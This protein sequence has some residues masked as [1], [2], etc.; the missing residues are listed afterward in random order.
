MINFIDA[1]IYMEQGAAIAWKR[2]SLI[3]FNFAS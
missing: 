2:N 1:T 3:L